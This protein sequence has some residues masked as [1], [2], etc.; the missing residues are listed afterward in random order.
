MCCLGN[1]MQPGIVMVLGWTLHRIHPRVKSSMALHCA[2]LGSLLLQF[3]LSHLA[4]IH[5]EN[6]NPAYENHWE[7]FRMSRNFVAGPLTRQLNNDRQCLHAWPLSLDNAEDPFSH[8]VLHVLFICALYSSAYNVEHPYV[9]MM[10]HVLFNCASNL[11]PCLPSFNGINP[12][13]Y[14]FIKNLQNLFKSSI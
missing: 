5:R 9:H 8:M 1:P 14:D 2:G 6:S 10:L 12:N 4:H 13:F 11:S 7:H 3:L